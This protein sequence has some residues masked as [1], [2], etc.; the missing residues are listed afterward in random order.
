MKILVVGNGGREHALLWKLKQDAPSAEFYATEPNPGMAELAD[1]VEIGPTDVDGLSSW[2]EAKG[3]T[4]TVVGPEFSLAH[5]IVD[6]FRRRGLPIFGPTSAAARI[7]SSKA[8][9]KDLMARAGVPTAS[10]RTFTRWSEAAPYIREIGA[11]I[12]VKASGLAAG[13]GA[14]CCPTLDEALETARGMLEDRVFGEAGAEIVVEEFLEGEE[15]S[16][17]GITDGRDVVL[18]LPSQDHKRIGEGDTG[19]NTGGMGAYA[20]VPWVGPDLQRDVREQVFLPVLDQLAG[21]AA[22]FRGLLYAGLMITQ[23]GP[24]VIEFNCRFG[25]PETQ[26]ILPLM[27]SSLLELMLPV[28][29]GGS[30]GA[31]EIRWREGA[32]LNTVLAS[33]GY[34]GSHE[35]GKEI[36]IP[37]ELLSSAGLLVFHS[38][39]RTEGDKLVTAG[40][41]VLSVVGIGDDLDQARERSLRGAEEIRFEGKTFRRD[42][43]RK[44]FESREAPRS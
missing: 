18:L 1:P 41:R 37:P 8:Y 10:H 42:I 13:K 2:A 4:L 38:G 23:D 14:V 31:P 11:P 40:G 6:A 22:P 30:V 39:T 43:G 15:L 25:D 33:G 24:R 9:A 16:V 5:G 19:P 27:E 20:P 26:A 34:P 35:K 36:T 21:A 28:A 44:A 29:R 32:A 12:V 3:I 7:E 17:F